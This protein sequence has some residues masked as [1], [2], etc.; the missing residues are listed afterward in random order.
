MA[1]RKFPLRLWRVY[2]LEKRILEVGDRLSLHPAPYRQ[3]E[4]K[5][6]RRALGPNVQPL[7][8]LILVN[9]DGER[10]SPVF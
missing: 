5:N 3:G 6:S 7:G 8:L 9:H 1:R 2:P 4:L 10:L